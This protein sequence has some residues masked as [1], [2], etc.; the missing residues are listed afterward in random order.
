[1]KSN[2]PVGKGLQ[3]HVSTLLGPFFINS[4]KTFSYDDDV[5]FKSFLEFTQNGRGPLTT[6]GFQATAL[7]TSLYAKAKGQE[8]WPD[9]QLT[10]FGMTPHRLF[11]SDLAHAFGLRV[12][13]FNVRGIF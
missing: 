10:L 13:F 11:S 4:K 1:V 12:Y 7:L 9:L 5:T 3:N 8:G 6:S 2:L